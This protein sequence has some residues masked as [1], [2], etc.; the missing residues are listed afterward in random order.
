VRE[1]EARLQTI[2]D[3][4]PA[5][6]SIFDRDGHYR[7]ANKALLETVGREPAAVLGR[8]CEEVLSRQAARVVRRGLEDVLADGEAREG[9][10]EYGFPDGSRRTY[11]SIMF[12]LDERAGRR[13]GAGVIAVDVTAERAAQSALVEAERRVRQLAESLQDVYLLWDVA[14]A[15]ILYVSPAVEPVLQAGRDEVLRD[16][17]ALTGHVH[18]DDGALVQREVWDRLAA[19]EPVDV[20]CRMAPVDGGDRWIR[21]RAE[22]VHEHGEAVTRMAVTVTDVSERKRVHLQLQGARAEAE[23]ANRRK[24]EFLSRMSHELRTPLNAILGFTQLLE[25]DELS[26]AQADNLRHVSRAGRH[27]LELIDDVLDIS[28]IESGEMRLSL[29]PVEV[30]G[31]VRDALEMV[32][33]LAASR[34]GVALVFDGPSGLNAMADRQRLA[35]VLLNL[36]SNALKYNRPDG[37]VEVRWALADPYVRIE[38]ADTGVGLDREAQRRLFTPLERFGDDGGVEGTGIGLALSRQL[39]EVMGGRIAVASEPDR[40]SV[41]T[42]ELD[43]GHRPPGGAVRAGAGAA[44][45]RPA[46]VGTVLYVED[47]PSNV[48]LVRR[49]LARIPA[50][51]LVVAGRGAEALALV[52]ADRPDLVLLDLH[53]PDGPGEDVLRRLH[54]DPW[55]A[56]IPVVVVTADATP[57]G[58][59]R[60]RAAGAR[61]FITK[62]FALHHLL[63]VVTD[64]LVPP[65]AGR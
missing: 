53:L 14:E 13:Y 3:V 10:G 41:F 44:V 51:R 12:P 48:E 20:E 7:F 54:E 37:R 25:L 17:A 27:L 52:A 18:P 56:D 16:P 64:L 49:T 59:E 38:V 22:P 57:G 32:Q 5:H 50:C 11:R 30:S 21:V 8:S 43:A 33:P 58:A 9:E 34:P 47:N 46:V 40:G 36:L 45:I 24:S 42:V 29:E 35:Q 15:R 60:L 39:V 2:L 4:A 26:A 62:P 31:V 28:R 55:S 6:I 61:G 23:E 1:T 65:P 19:S 63:D